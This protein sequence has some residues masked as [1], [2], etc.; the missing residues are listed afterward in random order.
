LAEL[1]FTP[2]QRREDQWALVDLVGKGG[3]RRLPA[4]HVP[5]MRQS[6]AVD[7]PLVMEESGCLARIGMEATGYGSA[8]QAL[9]VQ[10][11]VM[12]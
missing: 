4:S 8:R 6:P 2:L 9:R 3:H 7:F 11:M 12:T 1:D 10:A 5:L